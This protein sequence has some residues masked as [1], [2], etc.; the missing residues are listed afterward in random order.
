VK[1]KDILWLIKVILDSGR[2][3]E[4]QFGI[5]Y[6][7]GDDLFTP[8]ERKRGLPIGNLTSQLFANVYLDGFDHY[9]KEKLQCGCY[10][11]YM[12]DMVVFDNSKDP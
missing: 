3:P 1:D 10:I 11:R 5:S 7:S 4:D 8:L 6:F 12:D 9:V 2:E